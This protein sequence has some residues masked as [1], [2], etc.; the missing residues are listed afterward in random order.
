M[1]LPRTAKLLLLATLL[2]HPTIACQ[3][4]EVLPNPY[5]DDGREYV[6]VS[7]ETNCTLTDSED[8][9]SFGPGV[10]YVA[11]NATAFVD[12]YGFPPDAEGIRLSNSGEEITLK[13]E[14]G[15]DVFDYSFFTDDGLIYY[16][17]GGKWD[18][19]YEDWSSF[20]PVSDNVS[21]R[22]VVTPTSYVLRGEG[23]VA[24]Y[25]VTKDNFD[26]SFEFAVD[27]SPVG[28]IP[29][30]EMVLAKKYRF[31]FLEGSYRNFHYKFAVLGSNV[32]ITTENWKWDNR[33][34]IVEFE[35]E[36]VAEL[37]KEV[38]E[39]DLKYESSPG[40]VSDVK[41]SYREGKGRE[42]E[43]SGR[44]EVHVLPDSNPVFGFIENSTGF[45]Y[46]AVPYISF[47]WF[48]D[49][50]PLLSA[51][52]NASRRGVEVRVMLADYERNRDAVEFLSSLPGVEAKMVRS[53]EFDELHAKYLVTDGKVLITSANFNKY[54]LKLNREIAVVIESDEV[55]GFLKDVFEG[56]WEGRSE[57]SPAVSLTLLG[58]ALLAGFYLLRRLS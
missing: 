22:I 43:F 32:V 6:K 9:F 51:I 29:A 47:E 57:I 34:I 11:R 30:E 28:G 56:D 19:R 3:I 48:D 42:L 41:G 7:C 52:L 46:I 20:P 53:P 55:S 23:I 54:G 16:R 37:L 13:C 36:N 14:D 33:G 31:H 27:A 1:S 8:E 26:G 18:F 5:G 2:I 49:S 24:S 50:S 38:F 58:I 15:A 35:S 44:V 40:K 45:L 12:H 10:H 4:L 17:E 39:H 25:T 21:G